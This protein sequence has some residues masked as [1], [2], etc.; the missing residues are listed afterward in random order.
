MP[1]NY[2]RPQ[3]GRSFSRLNDE[4]RKNIQKWADALAD[5]RKCNAPTVGVVMSGKAPIPAN[6]APQIVQDGR[7]EPNIAY[8][9]KS[10]ADRSRERAE[11]GRPQSLEDLIERT[12]QKHGE[13]PFGQEQNIEQPKR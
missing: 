11:F 1:E 3:Y 5:A 13:Q 2:R 9:A 8:S 7:E 6:D 12:T 10:I 4:E